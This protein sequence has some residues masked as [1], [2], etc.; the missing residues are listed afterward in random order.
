MSRTTLSRRDFLR[1]SCCSATGAALA[2]GMGRFGL[3]NAYAQTSG[4]YQ[5]LVCIFLFGGND[6][7]NMLIPF[8]TQGLADYATARTGLALAPNLMLPITP[9]TNNFTG[10][11]PG[12][13]A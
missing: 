10:P 2:A 4:P 11:Y 3:V 12:T 8:T 6:G 7:N 9:K 5:A 1:L 13:F